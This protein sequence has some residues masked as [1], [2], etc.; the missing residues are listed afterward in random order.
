MNEFSEKVIRRVAVL[1][2]GVMG[3]QIAAHLVNAGLETF[4]FDLYSEKDAANML[5]Q[6]SIRALKTLKPPPLGYDGIEQY[7]IPANYN[8]DL[9]KLKQCDLIIE[10]IAERI[11]WKHSLYEKIAPFISKTAI[12]V[13]NTSGLKIN[14][15]ASKFPENVRKRFCGMHFFNPPRYMKLVELIPHSSN[16]QNFLNHLETFLVTHLGKGVV[17]AKDTPN[18]I[19]NRIGVFSLLA[20]LHHAEQLQLPPDVIDELTGPLLGRPKSATFRTMDIVGLDTLAHVVHTLQEALPNDPWRQYFVLPDWI[21]VL[22]EKGALGQKTRVGIYR[23]EGKTIQVYDP[24]ERHYRD[25]KRMKEVSVPGSVKKQEVASWLMTA[26][27]STHPHAQLIWRSF[28]DLFHYCAYHLTDIANKV[29]EI[30]DAMR[31]GYA[32]KQGPFEIWQRAGWE[33]VTKAMA[34]E[35]HEGLTMSEAPLPDWIQDTNFSGPYQE[36]KSYD[37]FSKNYLP[38][39]TLSVYRR[40]FFP[41]AQFTQVFDEGR[42]IFETQAVRLWTSN[43]TLAILSF[44]T[45]KNCI[46]SD[47]LAGIQEAIDRAEKEYDALILW[48]RNDRD[49]SVG[50]DLKQLLQWLENKRT[51]GIEKVVLEFQKTALRLKYA[52]IPTIAAIRG[53][54]LGGACEFSMHT[55]HVVAAFDSYVGLVEAR[56]G[57]LPGGAGSK[58]MAWRA[59]QHPGADHRAA[60]A[61]YFEQIAYAKVSQS[62]LDAK[63]MGYLRPSDTIVM[64]EDELLFMAK[65]KAMALADLAYTPPRASK[66]PVVGSAGIAQCQS[67]LI[68]LR[69]GQYISDYQYTVG[70]TIA[71]VLCGGEVE[72]GSIVSEAWMLHLEREAIVELTSY[73]EM[74]NNIRSILNMGGV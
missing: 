36:G 21:Q 23:K 18:F 37:P 42:T 60:I 30:D 45:Q 58:E 66:F 12:I 49:F 8:T 55:T 57:L 29:S 20:I 28:R 56:V 33:V 32:W 68:N 1:G 50:L 67:V 40:Q 54:T 52:A 13:T 19:G 43:D 34:Q 74:I 64:N 72:E 16:D 62:A 59:T 44:K 39:N 70:S 14:D 11:D 7:I 10:A 4:L 47:V 53:M 3:A 63:K 35:Q 65:K 46:N 6:H 51:D 41:D 38:V 61:K 5:A 71:R 27:A 69:E 24:Y 26:A 73:P 31:W 9:E 25:V 22:I 15:L 17:R 2:A 48:Q